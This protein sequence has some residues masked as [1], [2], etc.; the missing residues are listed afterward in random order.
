MIEEGARVVIGGVMD[1]ERAAFAVK[2]G[3]SASYVHLDVTKPAEWTS[4]VQAAT[5]IFGGL[6]V[7]VN[8]AGIS[9]YGL[10]ERISGSDWEKTIAINLTGVF[11]G[12]KAVIPA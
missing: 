1:S 2:L 12:I 6:N 10:I 4:A 9:T 7:L 8:N 11:N 3:P 5:R